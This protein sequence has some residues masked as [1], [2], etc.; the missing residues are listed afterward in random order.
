MPSGNKKGDQLSPRE[1]LV[2]S[3]SNVPHEKDLKME[4]RITQTT[5][6][7]N[8][9]YTPRAMYGTYLGTWGTSLRTAEGRCFFQY[10][11]TGLWTELFDR[12]LPDI[13]MAG[14]LDL[15]AEAAMFDALH[16]DIYTPR[17]RTS[18]PRLAA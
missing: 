2:A 13:V 8:P 4:T 14:R 5:T 9:P 11:E 18:Y 1:A 10:H 12:D 6:A 7:A 15:I 16:Q 17:S 3:I